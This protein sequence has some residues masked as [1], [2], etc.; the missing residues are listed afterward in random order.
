MDLIMKYLN[1]GLM[2]IL[3]LSLPAVLMAATVGLVV[4]ILQAVTQVQEQTIPAAPKILLVFLLLIFGGPL[5]LQMM[6]EYMREGVYYSMEVLPRAEDHVLP[7]T[8]P[9]AKAKKGLDKNKAFF[10]ENRPRSSGSKIAPMMERPAS[11]SGDGSAPN[12]K[13]PSAIVPRQ[14]ATEKYYLQKSPSGP[15]HSNSTETQ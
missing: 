1:D 11:P 13:V 4:G 15:G 12:K 8:L 2:L 9:F 10:K 3:M 5:M 6:E 7:P 14:K